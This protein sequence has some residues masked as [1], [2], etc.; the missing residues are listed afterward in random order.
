MIARSQASA[1]LVAL[2]LGGS[3][4]AQTATLAPS[5]ATL[6]SA[7]GTIAFGFNSTFSGTALFKLD[8]TIPAGWVYLSG[9]GEPGIKPF[10]GAENSLS[11]LDINPLPS[12]VQFSFT[13]SYP[14]GV[15]SATI[16]RSEPTLVM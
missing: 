3:A 13:V 12:P 1:V 6:N 2:A 16:A 11:W 5:A 14:A 8:V 4:F 9:T 10:P 7:G 15:S